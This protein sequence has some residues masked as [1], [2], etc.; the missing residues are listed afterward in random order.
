MEL[1]N[2]KLKLTGFLKMVGLFKPLRSVYN[3][4]FLSNAKTELTFLDLTAKFST[5][6]FKIKED[7]ESLLGESEVLKT[8]LDKL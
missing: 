5:P 7:V 1:Q 3:F 2:I 4:I 8:F 6:S